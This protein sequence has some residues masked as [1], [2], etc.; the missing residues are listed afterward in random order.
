P[1]VTLSNERRS[2]QKVRIKRHPDWRTGSPSITPYIQ[3]LLKSRLGGR[4]EGMLRRLQDV[5]KTYHLVFVRGDPVVPAGQASTFWES[6]RVCTRFSLN[7]PRWTNGTVFV[8]ESSTDETLYVDIVQQL[9]EIPTL[10][11]LMRIA[12][13]LTPSVRLS[14]LWTLTESSYPMITG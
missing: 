8:R 11:R 12:S 9:L 1:R 5:I 14:A 3:W 2:V 10:D 6:F 4:H 13:S 7:Q